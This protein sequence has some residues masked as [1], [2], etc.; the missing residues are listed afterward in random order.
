M[1]LG[2]VVVVFLSKLHSLIESIEWLTPAFKAFRGSRS[3][4]KSLIAGLCHKVLDGQFTLCK[5]DLCCGWVTFN[6]PYYT[7]K[8]YLILQQNASNLLCQ[9]FFFAVK[10]EK[11]PGFV[12]APE[13][14]SCKSPSEIHSC[15][16]SVKTKLPPVLHP[17]CFFWTLQFY[18]VVKK[19]KQTKTKPCKFEPFIIFSLYHFTGSSYV[20]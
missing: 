9:C 13:K 19:N 6:R 8:S 10:H 5:A 15:F 2:P 16:L 17:C 11:L 4:G 20:C 7:A 3:L 12:K 18:F 14:K 1:L